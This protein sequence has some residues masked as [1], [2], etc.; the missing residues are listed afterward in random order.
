MPNNLPEQIL[1][2]ADLDYLGTDSFYS[3]GNQLFNELLSFGKIA[4]ETEWNHL[5]IRFIQ[6]HKYHTSFAKKHREPAKLAHLK[7]LK[8]KLQ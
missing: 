7:R 5:Q 1:S 6:Q 3:I 4:D 8:E 2:D